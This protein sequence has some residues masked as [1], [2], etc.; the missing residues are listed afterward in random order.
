MHNSI[1]IETFSTIR[2]MRTYSD[3]SRW[4]LN[5][6]MK[7]ATISEYTNLLSKKISEIHEINNSIHVFI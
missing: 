6:E 4:I 2:I 5:D 3:Y 7:S 1:K